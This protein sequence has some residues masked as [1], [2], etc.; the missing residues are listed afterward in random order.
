ML[1]GVISS[2]EFVSLAALELAQRSALIEKRT[3][4]AKKFKV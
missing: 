2:R 1:R 3:P 4:M